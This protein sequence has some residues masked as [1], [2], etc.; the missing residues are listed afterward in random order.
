MTIL[1]MTSPLITASSSPPSADNQEQASASPILASAPRLSF[2]VAAL[3]ADDYRSRPRAVSPCPTDLRTDPGRRYC[4]SPAKDFS[5]RGL[6][7]CPK[8]PA[9]SGHVS[10]A[11]D[12]D[13]LVDIEELKIAEGSAMPG[14]VRPTPAYLAT[15]FPGLRGLAAL[16]TPIWPGSQGAV[17]AAAQANFFPQHF[18][19]RTPLNGNGE[20]KIKCNLRKHRPNRK[21]RTPFTT[22]Q[23]VSLERK[24]SQ[25]QYLSVAERAEFSSSLHLTETQVKIWFQNRRAKAKR[26]QEA[27]IE[28]MRLT[29]VS[30]HHTA[31]YS[32]H[33][34]LMATAGLYPLRML[35]PGLA[36]AAHHTVTGQHHNRD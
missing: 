2:S 13:S 22:Q 18:A 16:H 35:H 17:A 14:P 10:D 15:G 30:Q 33:P 4:D 12:A 5:V 28:K 36:S 3:L 32:S 7:H 29:A 24:F 25:R 20:L 11:E 19:D 31:L 1:R 6:Q 34:G 21:P 8:S 9:S 27:E 26:L 23:L